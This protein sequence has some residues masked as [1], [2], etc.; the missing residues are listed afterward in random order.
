MIYMDYIFCINM[1]YIDRNGS[2]F[3]HI[4]PGRDMMISGELEHIADEEYDEK[5]RG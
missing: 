1:Y 5:W 2:P 4:F 3:P